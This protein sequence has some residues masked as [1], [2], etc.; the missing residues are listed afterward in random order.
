[1]FID[2]LLYMN[3]INTKRL[4]LEIFI[5]IIPIIVITSSV[6]I[7]LR[8]TQGVM[9]VNIKKDRTVPYMANLPPKVVSVGDEY[10]F[11]P[12]VVSD[13]PDITKV[14]L[15][16]KPDWLYID[17]EGVVRGFPYSDGS[18]KVV[19]KVTD[20]YNSSSYIEYILVNE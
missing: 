9:G 12:K 17:N 18:F 10:I 1:M 19:F 11:V 7:F 4:L 2:T 3:Y 5:I 14:I 20:G 15:E 13:Y 8:D 16:Q 6:Y